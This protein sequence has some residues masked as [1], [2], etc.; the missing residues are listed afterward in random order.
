MN[1]IKKML[2]VIWILLA[3]AL[4]IFMVI[5]AYDKVGKAAEGIA[6]TNTLLQWAIIIII[7]IPICAGLAIFGYYAI[8]GEYD[9]L[10][11]NSDEL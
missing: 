5:Q 11:E 6:R 8:R 4:V 1:S 10:P 2:G 9:H 3:P 7:F